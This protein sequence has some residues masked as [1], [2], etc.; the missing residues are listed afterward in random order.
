MSLSFDLYLQGSGSIQFE[1][2]TNFAL[3]ELLLS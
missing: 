2:K 1:G 3:A